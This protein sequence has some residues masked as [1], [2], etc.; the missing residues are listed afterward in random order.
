MTRLRQISRIAFAVHVVLGLLV[1]GGILFASPF[2]IG[3]DRFND[4]LTYDFRWVLFVPS[5]LVWGLPIVAVLG[6]LQARAAGL[7]AQ[8]VRALVS[9]RLQNRQIPVTVD[10]DV[11]IPVTIAQPLKV[12]VEL[13]TRIPVDEQID[14]ETSV[15]IRTTLPL[16]TDIET[17]VPVLGAVRI[18]I[19]AQLP[20]DLVLPV[21]GK[22][23]IKSAGLPVDLK[24]EVV[25]HLPTFQVP[26]KTRLE[27]RIDVLD[28]LRAGEKLLK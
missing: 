5:L 4:V 16:D 20:I 8:R 2:V 11:Q 6:Y 15:P 13:N 7:E 22:I 1:L 12:P 10:V 25:V 24:E 18:P 17:H 9:E 26:L 21:V 27:T 14:I 28:T 3:A 19:R 23:R